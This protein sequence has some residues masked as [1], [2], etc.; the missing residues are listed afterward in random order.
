[1][2]D[3]SPLFMGID[4][5][6]QGARA[7]VVDE[8]GG[9]R[10]EADRPFGPP[11]AP[12]LPAGWF[13]QD[14][15]AWWAAARDAV[16]TCVAELRRGGGG[17]R[18]IRALA[19]TST[20]GTIVCIDAHGA[21]IGA[22]IM[23]NDARSSREAE[24][25][26]AA[27]A[28]MRG[29]LGYRFGSSFGLPKILWIK[30]NEPERFEQA[31]LFVHASDF[32]G[33]MICGRC[34]ATDYTNVLKTGYDVERLEWPA[35]VAAL[36]VPREKLQR[37]VAPGAP[38]EHVSGRCA[39]E[40]GL[41]Q[42]TIL[43]AGCT[44]GCASQIASGAVGVGDWNSTIGTTLIIKGVTDAIVK[45]PTGTV[46]SHRHPEGYWMPG[47]ASNIGGECLQKRFPAADLRS[48]DRAVA[49]R[50]PSSLIVYPLERGE[51]RFPAFA[52]GGGFVEGTPQ[53]EADLYQAYLEGV[54][55]VERYA[56]EMLSRLG[57]SPGGRIYVA[58]GAARSVEW[59]QIRANIQQRE[60]VKPREAG[61]H[62]G[63]AVLAASRTHYA[64]LME[65]AGRMVHLQASVPPQP[66]AVR[67][68]EE[69][70]RAFLAAMRA[71][72]Y[73]LQE[74]P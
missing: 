14:P 63:A 36:G 67:L 37:I 16:R 11:P 42:S 45:D 4:V 3:S 51:A 22:A 71:R 35:F 50:P 18:E 33:G 74:Q 61:A 59:T 10:A 53:D 8:R 13:E 72:G 52:K 62:M 34:D 41:A 30:D 55:Y 15:A 68:Y 56:F 40:T 6:T 1:M 58:G 5:G 73:L 43:A 27:S 38:L 66:Q 49:G 23:Y 70:Y 46:Y 19:V 29:R 69:R 47:G 20:S 44:D 39:D 17:A 31:R 9:V 7:I 26:N 25:A 12:A 60:L 2:A 65:A 32:V 24:R 48:L 64:T 21:P 54:G 57:A 28:E